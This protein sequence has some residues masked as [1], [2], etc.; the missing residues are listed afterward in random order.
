M[1]CPVS[2]SSRPTGAIPVSTSTS[3]R[4][5]AA[6]VLADPE[7]VEY[8]DLTAEQRF[9]ALQSGE[10]DVLVRNTTYTASRD[11]GDGC[12]LPHHHLLRRAGDDG[13][14]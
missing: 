6:G 2:G 8:V 7:A 14:R 12:D 3:A 13:L 4:A 5:I 11:G 9:T 10:V 1:R